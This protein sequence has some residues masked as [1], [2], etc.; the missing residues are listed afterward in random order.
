MNYDNEWLEHLTQDR[1]K[2]IRDT[3][4]PATI[5]ELRVLGRERF[6]SATDPWAESF[7]TFLDEHPHDRFYLARTVEGADVVYSR[8]ADK[9]VWF[10]AGRGMGILQAR[11][12]K[13]MAEI[14]DGR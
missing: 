12:L 13:L 14:V 10:L 1:E 3:V 9:G 4:R 6:P 5:E 7:K 8:D 2:S 11:G